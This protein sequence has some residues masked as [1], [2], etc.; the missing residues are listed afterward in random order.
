MVNALI[1]TL[2]LMLNMTVQP[3]ADQAKMV[4]D[5][6]RRSKTGMLRLRSM[7]PHLEQELDT[8]GNLPIFLAEV[9]GN[10]CLNTPR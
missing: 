1:Q 9:S 5:I 3:G 8:D 7:L 2:G 4:F 6:A 10:D